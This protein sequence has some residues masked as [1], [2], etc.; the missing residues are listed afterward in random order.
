MPKQTTTA[1]LPRDDDSA[2]IQILSPAVNGNREINATEGAS[3]N[4]QLP[5]DTEVVRVASTGAVWIAFGD[6]TITAT[7]GADSAIL[8]P[9]GVEY[10]F[11]HDTSYT[12]VAAR[13][14]A[15][16]GNQTVNATK[17]V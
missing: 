2:S 7:A 6:N 13:S 16:A 15:G 14:V 9:A 10:F 17:M 12:Y 8:M 11:L 5:T 1:S 4:V 3:L